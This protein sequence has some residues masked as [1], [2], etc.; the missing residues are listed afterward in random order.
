MCFWNAS[1]V[2]HCHFV[3]WSF[4]FH[5]RST[6][7][8]CHP[9]ER[10]ICH[11]VLCCVAPWSTTQR[12]RSTL[13]LRGF[14]IRN[15]DGSPSPPHRHYMCSVTQG[16]CL[17]APTSFGWTTELPPLTVVAVE[18]SPP[19]RCVVICVAVVM[20]VVCCDVRGRC[21]DKSCAVSFSRVK[22]GLYVEVFVS[23]VVVTMCLMCLMCLMCR[24]LL[25]VTLLGWYLDTHL[26]RL[27]MLQSWCA[28]AR[29]SVSPFLHRC[30]VAI[31]GDG[32]IVAV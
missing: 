24:Q 26:S 27:I 11:P 9:S 20:A 29:T 7:Q 4:P 2:S 18:M 6:C 28:A 15:H 31:L 12:H 14:W 23:L 25:V 19:W 16:Q 22:H 10:Q 30:H 17:L 1:F 13:H 32:V 5:H 8:I 21:G 3:W